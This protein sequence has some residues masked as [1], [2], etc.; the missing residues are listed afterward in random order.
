MHLSLSKALYM[1]LEKL[2]LLHAEVE[3]QEEDSAAQ[4]LQKVLLR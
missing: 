3:I 2:P 1:A 4:I